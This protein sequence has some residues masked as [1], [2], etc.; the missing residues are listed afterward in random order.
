M[1]TYEELDMFLREAGRH[2]EALSWVANAPEPAFTPDNTIMTL[3]AKGTFRPNELISIHIHPIG[4]GPEFPPEGKPL[5]HKH[6]YIEIPYLWA[7]PCRMNIEGQE[8]V[9][10]PGD[11]VILDT[12]STHSL[13][14]DDDTVLVNLAI[15]TKFFNDTFFQ[16]FTMDDPLAGFFA[17]TIYSQ[18]TAKRHLIF[19]SKN[20]PRV[21]HLFTMIMQEYFAQ[22][23]C[24]R[25][26]VESLVIVLFS[27]MVRLQL[28]KSI[29]VTTVSRE[30]DDLVSQILQFMQDNLGD[31]NRETI[32]N[33]FGYSYSYIT[34]ILQGATGMNFSQLKKTLR[35]QK[36]ELLLRT[37][38]RPIIA[39]AHDA[40]F[41]NVTS[42][43]ELFKSTYG[44][45]P[46]T[47]RKSHKQLLSQER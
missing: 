18:K 16:H 32:A 22:E 45:P 2:P 35:L 8:V 28:Q 25:S 13:H 24:Y 31:I 46:L 26:I 47:Y 9:L 41:S 30:T 38:D 14:T 19:E 39:V 42:F 7:G 6:D 11:F 44:L 37:T 4:E 23:V 29:R 33:H 36:A 1:M 40:G 21:R 5:P 20:D 15:E 10:S 34:T 17:N 27:T 3:G 43:Y 12:E